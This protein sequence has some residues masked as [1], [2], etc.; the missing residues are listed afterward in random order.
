MKA[1]K[2]RLKIEKCED[3]RGAFNLQFTFC[4]SQFAMLAL[5]GGLAG[6]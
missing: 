3:A 1:H 4:D 5:R 6:R 2:P